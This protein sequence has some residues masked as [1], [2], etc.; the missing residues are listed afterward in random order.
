MLTT[1][2]NQKV[3]LELKYHSLPIN[4]AKSLSYIILFCNV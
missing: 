2:G 4:L 1:N 3:K